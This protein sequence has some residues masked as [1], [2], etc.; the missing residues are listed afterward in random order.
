MDQNNQ[1]WRVKTVRGD[2]FT[3]R[4]VLVIKPVA[5]DESWTARVIG[6]EESA[7]GASPRAAV[8]RLA[9]SLGWDVCEIAAPGERLAS[10]S[11]AIGARGTVLIQNTLAMRAA[12]FA[13]AR[14]KSLEQEAMG[15]VQAR[16]AD[17]ERRLALRQKALAAIHAHTVFLGA[18]WDLDDAAESYLEAIK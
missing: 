5:R 12:E 2:T 9:L 18:C 11:V 15:D 6:H 7:Y 3:V 17:S 10:E 4:T 13:L 8:L 1:A 14:A 16:P